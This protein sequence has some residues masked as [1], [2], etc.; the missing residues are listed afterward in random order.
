METAIWLVELGVGIACL[1]VGAVSL[2]G[3]RMRVV[4]ALLLIAGLAAAG[5]ASTRLAGI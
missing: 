3:P 2:R 5:H 4:G 1:A